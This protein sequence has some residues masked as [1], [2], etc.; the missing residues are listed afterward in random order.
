MTF[1]FNCYLQ[2]YFT[3]TPKLLHN[4]LNKLHHSHIVN[5]TSNALDFFDLVR[6]GCREAE[7]NIKVKVVKLK[8]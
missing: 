4:F 7:H 6:P 5:R 8:V 3:L 1:C 2:R